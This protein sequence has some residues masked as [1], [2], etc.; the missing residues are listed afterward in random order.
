MIVNIVIGCLLVILTTVVHA[1]A[2]VAAL[3]GLK[4]THANRWA[5]ASRLTRVLVVGALVLIMFL[6]SV[7]E[8]GLWA[9]TYL[10]VGAISG[11]EKALYFSTVTYTTLGYGD[12]VMEESWQLLS[13]FE[14]AN[15]I[16]MFGWTTALIFALVQR[17]YFARPAA[18]EHVA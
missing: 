6:A 17:V 3:G 15:G 11:L 13:A 18:G 8:A 16:I 7:V 1:A 10:A 9:A 14:A 2:M 12:V 4:A 5:G